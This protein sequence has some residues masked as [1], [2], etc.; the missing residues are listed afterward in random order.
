MLSCFLLLI[1]LLLAL[2]EIIKWHA[3]FAAKA[4]VFV[5]PG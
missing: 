3:V 5:L 2:Y 4:H 1:C